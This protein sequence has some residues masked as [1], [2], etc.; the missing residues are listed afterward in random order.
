MFVCVC[1]Y[2]CVCC[3]NEKSHEY[4]SWYIKLF[5]VTQR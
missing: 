1:V 2:V 4:I 5:H 3:E